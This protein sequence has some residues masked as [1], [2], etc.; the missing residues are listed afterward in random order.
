MHRTIKN[1]ADE[2]L[3]FSAAATR[4]VWD[5]IVFRVSASQAVD[6][7]TADG[8]DSSDRNGF[9]ASVPDSSIRGHFRAF[10]FHEHA[11]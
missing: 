2:L 1:H 7:R 8:F 9:D 6:S 5:V 3:W 10:L 4:L 11:S